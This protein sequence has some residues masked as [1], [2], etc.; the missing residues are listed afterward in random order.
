VGAVALNS[1]TGK[2]GPTAAEPETKPGPEGVA[3][4]VKPDGIDG[5]PAEGA[6]ATP[7]DGDVL[8][9]FG[10]ARGTDSPLPYEMNEVPVFDRRLLH[11]CG[12]EAKHVSQN[13][14]FLAGSL[15]QE[16]VGKDLRHF[17]QVDTPDPCEQVSFI[18]ATEFEVL[19]KL[20]LNS[21]EHSFGCI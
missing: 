4:V 14:L 19:M 3:Q 1:G 16:T 17:I 8:K 21:S 12:S 10:K 6:C 18:P 15:S 13:A 11:P 20:R 9:E 5:T 7:A 2:A